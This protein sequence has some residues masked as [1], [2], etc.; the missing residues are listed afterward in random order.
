MRFGLAA[1]LLSASLAQAASLE[2][3]RDGVVVRTIDAA[4]LA[5]TCGLRPI[6][7]DDPYY[8]AR[9]HYRACPLAAVLAAGFASPAERLEGTDVFFRAL[10]GYMKPSTLSRVRED[11]GFVAFG[12][13]NGT[14]GFSKM[15]RQSLDPGP[16]Y[17]VWTKPAQR[18]THVYPWPYQLASIELGSLEREY[19]HT[20]PTGMA[21]DTS[22]W[23][24]FAIFRSD[25]IAC[26][27]SIARAGR[28]VPS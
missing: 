26:H 17:V 6:E 18:D 21:T 9:K 4:T 16:F 2:F 1:L 10:D 24:G 8:A 12:E 11:G 14:E 3:R 5:R 27:A 20:A 15:G 22:A 7:V 28:S 23:R 25:C 13:G 19:P